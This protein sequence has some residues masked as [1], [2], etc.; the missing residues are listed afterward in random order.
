MTQTSNS[1]PGSQSLKKVNGHQNGVA[2]GNGVANSSS[3]KLNRAEETD[4]VCIPSS[5]S[6]YCLD[7]SIDLNSGLSFSLL[8]V[9]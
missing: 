3:P 6:W 9:N 8:S 4:D 7:V 1:I 5:P 2:N